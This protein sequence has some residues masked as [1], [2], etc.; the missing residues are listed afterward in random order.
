MTILNLEGTPTGSFLQAYLTGFISKIKDWGKYNEKNIVH[1]LILIRL[2]ILYSH[3]LKR[4]FQKPEDNSKLL[5]VLKSLSSTTP[6]YS[7]KEEDQVWL[8]YAH[9]TL[10]IPQD[11]TL[12]QFPHLARSQK[13]PSGNLFYH[14]QNKLKKKLM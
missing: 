6:E 3:L 1:N 14:Q 11:I 8:Q 12:S 10:Q 5:E 9:F 4:E 7:S 2:A 13:A